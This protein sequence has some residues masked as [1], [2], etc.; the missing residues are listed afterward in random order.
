MSNLINKATTEKEVAE[1]LDVIRKEV[2][3]YGVKV[4]ET[5]KEIVGLAKGN[6]ALIES[7]KFFEQ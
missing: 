4:T 2:D 7:V 1:A 3:K 5:L 6:P